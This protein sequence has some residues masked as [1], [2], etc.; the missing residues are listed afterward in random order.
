MIEGVYDLMKSTSR[1]KKDRCPLLGEEGIIKPIALIVPAEYVTLLEEFFS[2][3]DLR[4][5]GQRGDELN[6]SRTSRDDETEIL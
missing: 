4:Q 5:S 2:A 6:F 3:E 1:E